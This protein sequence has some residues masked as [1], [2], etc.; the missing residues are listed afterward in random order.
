MQRITRSGLMWL[1]A[2]APGLVPLAGCD[3]TGH[4]RWP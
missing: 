1:V 2:A 3:N 4:A